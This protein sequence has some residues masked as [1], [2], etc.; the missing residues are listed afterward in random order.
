[1]IMI[2]MLSSILL[3]LDRIKLW[4]TFASYSSSR[5][6]VILGIHLTFH[7]LK[8]NTCTWDGAHGVNGVFLGG[9][10]GNQ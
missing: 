3:W 8:I 2:F 9:G 4:L 5:L 10:G 1:M 7:S 6:I